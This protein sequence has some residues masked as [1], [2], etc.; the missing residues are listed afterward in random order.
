M[1]TAPLRLSTYELGH[2]PLSLAWPLAALGAAGIEAQ[3]IEYVWAGPRTPNLM[4]TC[5]AGP[6]AMISGTVVGRTRRLRRSKYVRYC[7][8]ST[9]APPRPHPM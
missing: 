6:F 1:V 5:E 4:L 7:L 2:Q 9:S 3:A 8:C